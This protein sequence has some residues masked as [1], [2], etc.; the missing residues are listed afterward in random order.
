MVIR[1][2][3]EDIAE[4][5]RPAE[6]H[7]DQAILDPLHDLPTD[8]LE[9]AQLMAGAQAHP[10]EVLRCARVLANR[11]AKAPEPV[12]AIPQMQPLRGNPQR[13]S[14]GWGVNIRHEALPEGQEEPQVGDWVEIERDHGDPW[15]RQITSI[16]IETPYG[17]L[18]RT[19]EED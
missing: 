10:Y 18:C 9:A 14:D 7:C 17:W 15:F 1:F 16:E 12:D 2:R 3:L 4:K 11:K 5:G 19:G 6:A 8:V 13:F